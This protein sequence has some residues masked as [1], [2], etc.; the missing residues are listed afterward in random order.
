MSFSRISAE[1]CQLMRSRRR[2]P[3]LNQERNR[4]RRSTSSASKFFP[5][6]DAS[7]R[8]SRIVTSVSVPP[9]A[10]LMRRMSSCRGA[11]TAAERA[12]RV[13]RP[14]IPLV[15]GG[16]AQHSRFVRR[17]FTA[18]HF[19]EAHALRRV[20]LRVRIDD[21]L[22]EGGLRGFAAFGKQVAA[23]VTHVRATAVAQ[24]LQQAGQKSRHRASIIT[25]TYLRPMN[26][27]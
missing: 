12:A 16:G 18:Q 2:K 3:R 19:E 17:K 23:Q 27:P 26:E 24:R 21:F 10:V 25:Q 7:S 9:G 6:P 1:V 5:F 22:R 8:C 20:H 15:R 13:F 11:S 14:G 4:C